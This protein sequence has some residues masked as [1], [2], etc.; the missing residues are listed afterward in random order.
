MLYNKAD[1]GFHRI[2]KRIKTNAQPLLDE[3]AN[4]AS[5]VHLS[6]SSDDKEEGSDAQTA[7]VGDLEPSLTFLQSLIASDGS[8]GLIRNNLSSLFAFE[9]DKPKA[10]TPPPPS[11]PQPQARKYI[12]AAERKWKWEEREAKAKA[13]ALAG[14]STRAAKAIVK[15]FAEEAGVPAS[16]DVE[17][18]GNDNDAVDNSRQPRSTRRNAQAG[19]SRRPPSSIPETKSDSAQRRSRLER[20]VVG[21]RAVAVL[22]D[23]ERREQE[24]ALDLMTEEV[25]PHAQF[26]RFNVG[27]VLPEGSKRKRLERPPEPVKPA[28]R[29]TILHRGSSR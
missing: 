9:M 20:G 7:D 21:V 27:W 22:S 24:K 23:K 4:D 14:R 12:S 29:L 25:D 15:A 18:E 16:S 26:K 6:L 19:P 17:G 28:G 3:L 13:R 5:Q 1:T 8:E 2:A 11:P 10:P